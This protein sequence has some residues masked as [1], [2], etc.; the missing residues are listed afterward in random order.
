M[1]IKLDV[2]IVIKYSF[3]HIA[4]KFDPF[5]YKGESDREKKREKKERELFYVEIFLS[6]LT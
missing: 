3:D 4:V 6:T 1:L 2:H 5:V